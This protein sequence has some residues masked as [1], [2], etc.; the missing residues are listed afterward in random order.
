MTLVTGA[1][2]AGKSTLVMAFFFVI[3]GNAPSKVISD[4]CETCAVELT[5]PTLWIRRTRRPNRVVCTRG[6][7]AGQLEDELA[8]EVIHRCFGRFFDLTSYVPQQYQRTFLYQSPTEKLE[9]LERLCFGPVDGDT[10]PESLKKRCAAQLK[11]LSRR[12]IELKSRFET[13]K[14]VCTPVEVPIPPARP[15]HDTPTTLRGLQHELETLHA[16]ERALRTRADLL[17]QQE[18]LEAQLHSAPCSVHSLSTLHEQLRLRE[19][20]ESIAR[21]LVKL[22]TPWATHTREES[23]AYVVDYTRDIAALQEFTQLQ[24]S[25]ERLSKLEK[26]VQQLELERDHLLAIHEGLFQCPACAVELA[27]LNDEL[28]RRTKRKRSEHHMGTQEKKEKIRTLE[29]RMEQLR[30]QYKSLDHYRER[31]VEL[32]AAIQPGE[33]LSELETDLAWIRNYIRE[34]TKR[35]HK[36]HELVERQLHVERALLPELDQATCEHEM[37]Q[38]REQQRVTDQLSYL[39]TRLRETALQSNGIQDLDTLQDRKI[40][41]QQQLEQAAR[42]DESCERYELQRQ[43][44]ERFVT[45]RD[46]IRDLERT[47]TLLE[48][49]MTAMGELRQ[50]VLKTETEIIHRKITQI[51]EHVNSFAENMFTEPITVELLTLKKTATQNEKVQVQLEVFYKNMKCDVSLLSGGEQARLNLAF[52]LAFAHTFE[53]PLLLLDECTSH[54]DQE[55]T[56][57]VIEQINTVGIPKVILIAHQLVEG[58]FQDIL[59]I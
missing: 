42:Y 3:T 51:A 39:R 30:G 43:A 41:L 12:H 1:S 20:R 55:L 24:Q 28:V 8:Q 21:S 7:A 35:E 44:Y 52:I 46:E 33:S 56:E 26:E 47:L 36:Q 6:D 59:A 17:Q 4:G 38:L 48:H 19:E 53:V 32:E 37:E 58:N 57:T 29:Q 49:R 18:S 23:E 40:Q 25:V 13:L 45:Q 9:S 15:P 5:T 14:H 2:G 22:G 34:E 27:L 54:L 10:H 11:E 16:Q 50:L 31:L